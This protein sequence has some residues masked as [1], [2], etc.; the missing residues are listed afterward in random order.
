MLPERPEQHQMRLERTHDSGAE[1]WFCPV[2]GRRFLMQWPP[3]YKKIILEAGD[4]YALHSGAKGGFQMNNME[5][6]PGEMEQETVIPSE[7][8]IRGEKSTNQLEDYILA[9][10][11]KARLILWEK[12]L[13]KSDF[14][15]LWSKE[16]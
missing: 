12:W 5:I 4:E 2:C 11:D 1:E 15:S 9:E 14:D 3:N 10:E 16:D 6:K 8:H 7:S 13:E